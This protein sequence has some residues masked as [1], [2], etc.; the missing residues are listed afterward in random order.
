[1]IVAKSYRE[2]D[3]WKTELTMGEADYLRLLDIMEFNGVLT[4]RPAFTELVDNA[5]A[6]AAME[7]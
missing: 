3:S 6:N 5:T 2:T 1:M 7:N 4:G